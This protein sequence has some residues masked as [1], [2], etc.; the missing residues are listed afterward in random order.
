M[1]EERFVAASRNSCRRGSKMTNE[2]QGTRPVGAR[3]GNLCL[4]YARPFAGKQ[5]SGISS[6]Q[7]R[8]MPTPWEEQLEKPQEE[9]ATERKRE[10]TDS[11]T[12]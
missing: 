4:D 11:E 2:T 9:P 8:P 7:R 6:S 5:K 3:T 12:D 10:Y 1:D